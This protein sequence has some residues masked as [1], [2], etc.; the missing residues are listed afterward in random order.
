MRIALTVIVLAG[1]T[2]HVFSPPGRVIPLEAPAT[3]GEGR[4]G[5]QIEGGMSSES[6][7]EPIGHGTARVRHG[8]TERLEIN[9]EASAMVFTLGDDAMTDAHRGIY[10]A[11]FGVKGAFGRHFALTSGLAGGWSAGGGFLSP[12][13][14]IVTGWTNNFVVPFI[15]TRVFFSQPLNATAV[16]ITDNEETITAEPQPSYGVSLATGIRVPFGP[17]GDERG[18]F[19]TGFGFTVI[20]DGDETKEFS[21]FNVGVELR[22]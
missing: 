12:D 7:G 4:T 2:P 9:G 3:V 21:G 6:F 15:S 14:G 11:R 18:A 8:L 13:I 1:C 16:T 20:S 22:L 10:S 17:R 5:I 19:T